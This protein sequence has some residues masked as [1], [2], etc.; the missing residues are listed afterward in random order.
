MQYVDFL[1]DSAESLTEKIKTVLP[2]N[3]KK[4]EII[5]FVDYVIVIQ[6][7][8]ISYNKY[9]QI[10]DEYLKKHLFMPTIS[11]GKKNHIDYETFLNKCDDRDK[12]ILEYM[13]FNPFMV[14]ITKENDKIFQ[15]LVNRSSSNICINE[16]EVRSFSEKLLPILKEHWQNHSENLS[17][18]D[19]RKKVTDIVNIM[20]SQEKNIQKK[21]RNQIT[22]KPNELELYYY[23]FY[24]VHGF[25]QKIGVIDQNSLTDYSANSLDNLASIIDGDFEKDKILSKRY[26]RFKDYEIMWN[27][28]DYDKTEKSNR[29]SMFFGFVSKYI[30]GK[31]HHMMTLAIMHPEI[32]EVL[33]TSAKTYLN[34]ASG[35]IGNPKPSLLDKVKSFFK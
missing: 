26:E 6:A 13:N 22:E 25:Y 34:A 29:M 30:Y 19:G 10:V 15:S 28:I 23:S 4:M 24:L 33:S 18:L 27:Q 21:I 9:S 20:I 31:K 35:I 12:R 32:L 11:I 16:N 5:Y 14:G 8:D 1:I 2:E 3:Y 7:I 17:K